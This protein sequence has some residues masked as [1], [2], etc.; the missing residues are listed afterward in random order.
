MKFNCLDFQIKVSN[1]TVTTRAYILYFCRRTS[2]YR[3]DLTGSTRRRGMFILY[4][5]FLTRFFI[6]LFSVIIIIYT[7]NL[8]PTFTKHAYRQFIVHTQ[9]LYR[10]RAS[11][12]G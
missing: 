6:L 11:T 2:V 4:I 9:Q 1:T 5:F 12:C 10:S 8:V 7:Y 3:A